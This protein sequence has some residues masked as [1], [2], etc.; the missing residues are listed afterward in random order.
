MIMIFRC[1]D[2]FLLFIMIYIFHLFIYC[3]IVLFIVCVFQLIFVLNVNEIFIFVLFDVWN[4][5]K[6]INLYTFEISNIHHGLTIHF[7]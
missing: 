3:N 7:E 1:V 5:T 4:F 2:L 6:L